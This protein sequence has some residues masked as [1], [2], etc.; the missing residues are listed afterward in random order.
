MKNLTGRSKDEK[1]HRLEIFVIYMTDKQFYILHKDLP[2]SNM[3][4]INQYN[5][6][7]GKRWKPENYRR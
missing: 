3:E 1:N 2:G 4:A 6:V 7:I 5:R